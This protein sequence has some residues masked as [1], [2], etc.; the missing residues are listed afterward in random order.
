MKK[1]IKILKCFICLI[2]LPNILSAWEHYDRVI[3]VVN[4]KPI[5]ESEVEERLDYV[6]KGKRLTAAQISAERKK[7]LDQFIED[8]LVAEKSDELLLVINNKRINDY[9]IQIMMEFFIRDDGNQNSA[10]AKTKAAF[11]ELNSLNTKLGFITFGDIKNPNLKRFIEHIEKSVNTSFQIFLNDIKNRMIKEQLMHVT[12]GASPPTEKE[13]RD[14]Y[15]AN[16]RTQ[17]PDEVHVKHIL[18]VPK[19]GGFRAERDA[20]S[21]LED[22]RKR[23]LAGESFERLAGQYS[24]DPAN[25]A[26]GGDLG[27]TM[28]GAFD[29]YF[30]GAV[31]QMRRHGEISQPIKSSFGYHLV[32]F[33]GRRKMPFEK[34]EHHIMSR[35][36][37]ERMTEQFNKWIAQRRNESEIIFY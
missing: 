2:F 35:L 12:G 16:S 26:K 6:R 4:T 33:M 24:E 3:A 27:W 17:I 20:S 29:P 11:N 32:K 1:F 23:I 36:Y 19:G 7:I 37:N 14:W 18:I 34:V 10:D 25:R 31:N 9:L 21:T 8:I 5:M 15:N 28:L 22:L 13:A 30:A